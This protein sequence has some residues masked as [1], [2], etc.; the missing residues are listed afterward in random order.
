[1]NSSMCVIGPM[2]ATAA[3]L[4]IAYRIMAQPNPSDPAQNLLAVS[5]PPAP[6]AKKYIGLCH[7]WL[8]TADPAVQAVFSQTLAHLTS[9]QGGGYEAVDIHLPYLREAQ[10]AHGATCLTESALDAR[11]RSPAH[12][13]AL[14]SAANRLL[15]GAGAQTPA[16][17]Y[18]AYGRL[19]TA[20]MQ[21]LAWLFARHPG[22]LVL[23]PATPMAGWPRGA[24]DEAHGFSDGNWSMR[25]MRFAWLA[26]T[27]G[28]PAVSFPAGY[29]EA[30]QGEGV[31][32]VGLMAM[33]EWGEEERLLGFARERERYL[34]E[35][36]PGG[37]TRPE[38][39]E[40]VIGLAREAAG[41]GVVEGEAVGE[42]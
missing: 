34:N 19:R 13:L 15:V 36:Y 8:A 18:L 31:L 12:P 16:V 38:E 32:P 14:L 37:R 35:V 27:S 20:V 3:D 21:H 25:S 7:E 5:V 17:D 30:A 29:V 23:T 4:T 39:W 9:P 40:D 6:S 24:G 22:L 42:E 10:V 1:M 26:N 33:G 11:T 28:C 2:A 41:K